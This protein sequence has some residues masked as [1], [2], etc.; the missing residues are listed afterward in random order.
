MRLRIAGTILA[1]VGW[2]AVAFGQDSEVVLG[3]HKPY[4]S[5]QHFAFEVRFA[6][7]WPNIDSEPSLKG[8]RPYHDTFGDHPWARL[9]VAFEFDWQALRIPHVGT[10]GPGLSAGYTQMSA[11]ALKMDGSCCSQANTNLEIFPFYTA[12][13]FRLDALMR[14]LRIPIVPYAK[15]GV[16]WGIWRTWN[17]GTGTA[18]VGNSVGNGISVGPHLAAGGMLQLSVFD[19]RSARALDEATGINNTYL[20]AEVMWSGLGELGSGQL[21]V[22]TTTWVL[23]L[24]IEL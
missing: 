17:D 23:G 18:K 21:R 13:V 7:Y 6:P 12:A 4:A 24:A 11:P 20:H 1:L 16:G 14:D 22:G 9:L 10:I 3:H 15:A 8:A 2:P 19:P 5:P